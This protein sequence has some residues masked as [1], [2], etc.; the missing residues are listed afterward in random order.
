METE[1]IDYSKLTSANIYLREDFVGGLHKRGRKE[2]IFKY[3]QAWIDTDRGGIGLSLPTSN[4]EYNSNELLPFFDNLIPEGWLLSHAQNIYKIDKKDRFAILLATGRETIGAVRVIAVD[5]DGKEITSGKIDIK[6]S[7]NLAKEAVEFFPTNDK[8]PYCLKVLTAKQLKTTHYHQS[9]AL[10][11]WGTVKKIN[12][13]LDFRDPLNSF[14]QTIYGASI[15]GAQRKGLF[16]FNK[17][18]ELTPTYHNAQYIIKP[19]SDIYKYLPEN[20]HVTMAIA[21]AF[22]FDLPPFTIFHSE[23]IGM[24]FAIKR[25]DILSEG[26]HLRLEDTGQVLE[27]PSDEKYKSSYEQL[28]NAINKFSD[29]PVADLY[30]MWKRLVFCFFIG[31]GDMHLKNWSLIELESKKGIFRLSP[32][33]DFLNTRLPIVDED[34]DLGLTLDGKKHKVT[35]ELFVNFAKRLKIEHM[36]DHTFSQLDNWINLAT[37]MVQDCYLPDEQKKRYIKIVK[38]RYEALKNNKRKYL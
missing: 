26:I 32:C 10:K 3:D 13:N 19:Q 22:G 27:I 34:I 30:E 28:A 29:A 7:N 9:C 23:K 24:V 38:S 1:L 4:S 21:K 16:N 31:N 12:L 36:V 2:Y 17:K 14:R 18:G 11:M 15:S 25:F 5:L 6:R 35:R 8:C 33:Y 20:E 37:E